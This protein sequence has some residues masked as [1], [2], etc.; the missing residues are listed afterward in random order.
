MTHKARAILAGATLLTLLP[1]VSAYSPTPASAADFADS[2]F[3]N[4]WLRTDKPVVDGTLKRSFYWGP[5]PGESLMEPYAQGV[6]GYRRVQY[7]DKSRMEINDPA[8]DRSNPFFVTNGLLTVELVSGK[9]QVGDAEYEDRQPADIPLASDN[10]DSNAPTYASFTKLANTTLGDHPADDQ[11]GNVADMTVDKA[12]TVATDTAYDKYSVK[13]GFY[14]TE[15]QHNIADQIWSFLNLS[16]PVVNPDGTMS[17]AKLSDPWFYTTGYAISEPYW[18]NVKVAGQQ[19]DVL[20]QLFQRRVV[21][22]Q[23]DAPEGFKVQMGNIGAHY[24]DWRYKSGAVSRTLSFANYNLEPSSVIPA[25]APYQVASGLSNVSNKDDFTLSAGA[26]DLLEQNN[27]VAQFPDGDQ[28]KQFFQLYEDG[29]YGE[30]PIFVTTDSVLHIYHLIFDKLLRDTET[31]YLIPDLQNL[32]SALVNETQQQYNEAKGTGAEGAALRNLGYLSVAAK[33]IDP[34]FNVPAEVADAVNTDLQQIAAHASLGASAV[35]ALGGGG[36]EYLEDFTQY[37]PR[38]H[39]TRSEDLER[40]FRTMMWFGRITFRL[41][42]V[43]ETRSALLLTQALQTAKAGDQDAA[44]MWSL[45]YDPTSFFVGKSDDL[46]YRDY[47]PLMAQA[48][49]PNADVAATAD[50][51]NIA[52]FQELAK[53]LAG[54]KVNSMVVFIDEDKEAVT[55]GMRLMGQRFTLDEYT[56]GQ[57]IWRNVGTDDNKRWL[58]KSLDFAAALGSSEAYSILDSQ[59]DTQYAK[60]PQQMDKVR[61]EIGT[62]AD[63][64][65]TENLYWS[66]LYSFRPLLQPKAENSGYP[67]FM[68]NQAWTRKDLNTVNG[69]YTELKHD[70]I[71]YAKQVMAEMGGGPPD[72]IKGYAEPEPEFY[73][74][75][76]ALIGMTRDGLVS[77]GLLEV[78]ENDFVDSDY[79]TLQTMYNTALDLKH[80]S[81]KEL[82]N[83]PLTDDEYSLIMFYGGTLEHITA[84]ASDPVDPNTQG[85]VDVNDQDAAVVADI[86]TGGEAGE[87]ALEEGTGRI[88]EIYVVVPIEGKLVLTRGG[89]YSQYEFIQPTSNRLTD[90]Q[91][92]AQLD[93]GDVPPLGD[94][95]TFIA[96]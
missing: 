25:V 83:Q 91:W 53:S 2:A 90:E 71:L 77:R 61:G 87:Q 23:P 78:P 41:K 15:T 46:T 1:A 11:T 5:I 81:E 56:F 55:K 50:D 13:Y 95:K 22:Y 70:T 48:L 82:S 19:T 92:R 40:Y 62:L 69:S 88:M 57:L 67:S 49:G 35:M 58:P 42:S 21:T 86:A 29:R 7:F 4:V 73:A 74:R 75:I 26:Q 64:Q 20:V 24:Y 60:Y 89:I 27:F 12:G 33:L 38:G 85:N 6:D 94:W 16:G 59:G 80:I 9:M 72:I 65:W 14:N 96:P 10:D 54:P 37:V 31:K 43:D 17:D 76:A 66:W 93:S 32:T 45:I 68:T 3:R 79:N 34:N 8:G 30:K 63:S 28:Y 47:A 84:A 36:D 18:A 51:A 39:Y 44:T 52:A